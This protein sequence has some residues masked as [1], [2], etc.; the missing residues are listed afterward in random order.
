MA[1]NKLKLPQILNTLRHFLS[2]YLRGYRNPFCRGRKRSSKYTALFK[3]EAVVDSWE[4]LCLLLIHRKQQ[5][6][7]KKHPFNV[8]KKNSHYDLIKYNSELFIVKL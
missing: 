6:K 7:N 4:P 2:N 5:K 8:I 1:L 3:Q